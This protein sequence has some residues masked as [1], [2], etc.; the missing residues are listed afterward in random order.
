MYGAGASKLA[1]FLQVNTAQANGIINS[2]IGRFPALRSFFNSVMNVCRQKG[3]LRTFSGRRR[4]FPAIN[5]PIPYL[6]SQAERQAINFLIQGTAADVCKAAM[7]RTELQLSRRP[8]IEA[9]LLLQIHDEL[10]WEVRDLHLQQVEELVRAAMED[11]TSLFS[12]TPSMTIP[13]PVII[14]TGKSWARMSS[15]DAV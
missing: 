4:L 14:T 10:L 13:L 8:D 12:G 15:N 5:S 6:R 7:L 11:S 2:F 1:E 9:Y 3:E